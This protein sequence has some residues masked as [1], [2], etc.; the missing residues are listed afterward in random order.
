MKTLAFLFALITALYADP[1]TLQTLSIGS[2]TYEAATL[3]LETPQ[4]VLIRHS[5]GTARVAAVALSL[6]IQKAL[7]FDP[8][9]AEAS[10]KKQAAKAAVAAAIHKEAAAWEAAPEKKFEVFSNTPNGLIVWNYTRTTR[11]TSLSTGQ[12][13]V[14]GGGGQSFST[15]VWEPLTTYSFIP[16]NDETRKLTAGQQFFAKAL[17]TGSKRMEDT[18]EMVTTCDV[19]NVRPTN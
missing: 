8:A 9:A 6:E 17:D 3:S 16:H 12:A 1:V 4:T 2:K 14:G 18:E 15:T 10:R 19:K 13:R 7:G 11:H 5:A